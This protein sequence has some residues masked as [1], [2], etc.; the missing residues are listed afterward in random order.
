MTK[1]KIIA[2]GIEVSGREKVQ[3]QAVKRKQQAVFLITD[4]ADPEFMQ[5][6]CGNPFEEPF[7]VRQYVLWDMSHD[8]PVCEVRHIALKSTKKYKLK[9]LP[10]I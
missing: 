2:S 5:S 7:S 8:M 4:V 3:G 1:G 9:Q 10:S 6:T